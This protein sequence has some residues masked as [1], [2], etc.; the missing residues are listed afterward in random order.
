MRVVF[1]LLTSLFI[2]GC[3]SLVPHLEIETPETL[4]ETDWLCRSSHKHKSQGP[5][6]NAVVSAC[7][8]RH[9]FECRAIKSPTCTGACDA[10]LAVEIQNCMARWEWGDKATIH[11]QRERTKQ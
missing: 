10:A 3:G 8:M 2:L 7:V 9:A 6:L 5:R 4:A 1:A 11:L